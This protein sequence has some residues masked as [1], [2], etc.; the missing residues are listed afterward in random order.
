MGSTATWGW[1]LFHRV[2]SLG[3]HTCPHFSAL[4]LQAN[5][6]DGVSQR[7]RSG[8]SAA[9]NTPPAGGQDL[10]LLRRPRVFTL[11]INW[12]SAQVR[13]HHTGLRIVTP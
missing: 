3:L 8:V 9:A 12:E 4:I 1:Y 5:A 7:A 11:A 10:L 6:T 13:Q 2:A